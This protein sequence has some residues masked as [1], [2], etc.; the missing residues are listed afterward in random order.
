MTDVFTNAFLF[1][2]LSLYHM[3]LRLTFTYDN[4]EFAISQARLKPLQI[5]KAA[6]LVKLIMTTQAL[7]YAE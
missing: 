5:G 2:S 7:P 3:F 4:T 6:D 1:I